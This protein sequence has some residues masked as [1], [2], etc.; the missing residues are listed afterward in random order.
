MSPTASNIDDTLTALADPVRR[1]IIEL[2]KVQ[3]R[4]A[5]ELAAMLT[6]SAPM[7]SKHLK[8]LRDSALIEAEHSNEDARIRVYRLRPN[9][10]EELRDW[11]GDVHTFWRD[12]LGAFKT[13]A[14]AAAKRTTSQAAKARNR[15]RG[16]TRR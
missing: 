7:M 12:Q 14:D 1:G 5:G 11:L 6:T 3:P 16:R 15:T 2:L 8:L 4:R 13:A 10:F 9:R